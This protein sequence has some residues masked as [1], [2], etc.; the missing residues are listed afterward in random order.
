MKRFLV[1]CTIVGLIVATA[2][3]QTG[4]IVING[5][6][7]DNVYLFGAVTVAETTEVTLDS[8]NPSLVGLGP[9]LTSLTFPAD[10]TI[11]GA[12]ISGIISSEGCQPRASI[13]S[14]NRQRLWWPWLRVRRSGRC[15]RQASRA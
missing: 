2:F 12:A 6:L 15:W 5:G 1:A 10:G 11:T 4:V 9:E 14:A 7:I 3:A 8:T 13:S